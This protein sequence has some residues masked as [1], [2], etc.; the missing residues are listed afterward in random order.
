MKVLYSVDEIMNKTAVE[1][2]ESYDISLSYAQKAKA[3]TK[4][5]FLPILL[6]KGLSEE[7]KAKLTSLSEATIGNYMKTL[8]K[9]GLEDPIQNSKKDPKHEMIFDVVNCEP[10]TYQEIL[11][12]LKPNVPE[13]SL[14][15]IH[16]HTYD[17]MRNGRLRRSLLKLNLSSHSPFSEY[18]LIGDLAGKSVLFI[19]NNEGEVKLGNKITGKMPPKEKITLGMKKCISQVFKPPK[20]PP[21]SFNII[22]NY[23]HGY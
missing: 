1:V 6:N 5:G 7:E 12:K 21:V 23:A 16:Y 10:S 3:L 13:I 14:P 15:S 19:P 11:D 8:R 17:M 20:T 22:K 4:N 9:M 18:G 2:A